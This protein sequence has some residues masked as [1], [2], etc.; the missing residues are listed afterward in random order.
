VSHAKKSGKESF[1]G[2]GLKIACG[3][4]KLQRG[5]GAGCMVGD[6]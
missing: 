3:N 4:G 2:G 5:C 1:S 6:A